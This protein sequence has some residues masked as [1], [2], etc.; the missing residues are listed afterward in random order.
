M[1]VGVDAELRKL[2]GERPF[3]EVT[4][5]ILNLSP[6]AWAHAARDAEL[7]EVLEPRSEGPTLALAAR[8]SALLRIG[9]EA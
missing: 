5:A 3:V 1:T 9:T 2:E 4:V 7:L 8:K 6:L